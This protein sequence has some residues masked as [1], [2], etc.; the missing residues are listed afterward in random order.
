SIRKFDSD[1]A[2]IPGWPID[3]PKSKD[4]TIAA[5]PAGNLLLAGTMVYPNEA[6]LAKLKPHGSSAWEKT[7]PLGN[8]NPALP[9][10]PRHMGNGYAGGYGTGPD[11]KSSYWWIKKFRS[12]GTEQ[13]LRAPD[14]GLSGPGM[15]N[16]PFLL[17]INA[18][19]D[20][21]VLGAGSGWRFSGSWLE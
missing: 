14:L 3:L 7:V 5:E 9:V 17:R 8:L 10:A 4:I 15:M 13:A 1:G 20:L 6:W 18:R 12:D 19:D 2:D 21:Y 16:M 11:E